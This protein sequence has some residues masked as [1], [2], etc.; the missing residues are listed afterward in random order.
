MK[1]HGWPS[2]G[3]KTGIGDGCGA[4]G[5]VSLMNRLLNSSGKCRARLLR[6]EHGGPG[7]IVRSIEERVIPTMTFGTGDGAW[8]KPLHG[9]AE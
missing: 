9:I 1:R 6:P 3:D 2:D 8:R 4:E 5:E 7:G